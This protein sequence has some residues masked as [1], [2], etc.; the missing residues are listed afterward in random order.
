MCKVIIFSSKCQEF[1]PEVLCRIKSLTDYLSA[2]TDNLCRWLNLTQILQIIYLYQ[3]CRW[4]NLSQ[5]SQISQMFFRLN[6]RPASTDNHQLT[7]ADNHSTTWKVE[8]PSGASGS[9]PGVERSETLG[10][11][12]PIVMRLKNAN[13]NVHGGYTRVFL[14]LS[15]NLISCEPQFEA[16]LLCLPFKIRQLATYLQSVLLAR[17][18]CLPFKIRQLATSAESAECER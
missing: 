6:G 1:A 18:L 13:I 5:I 17:W 3:L 7:A 9:Y 8:C 12:T 4:L 10:I 2:S 15:K 11:M 16:F 14:F